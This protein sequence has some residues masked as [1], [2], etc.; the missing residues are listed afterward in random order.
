MEQTM[1]IR[2]IGTIRKEEKKGVKIQAQIEQLR[3]YY[4]NLAII[5]HTKREFILDFCLQIPSQSS[6]QLV[7]RLA[8][9]PGHVKAIHK[10]LGGV[11]EEYEKQFG[12][13]EPNLEKV[14][15]RTKSNGRK[16]VTKNSKKKAKGKVKKKRATK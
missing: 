7:A 9:S 16:L 2:K 3:A 13:I 10:V 6:T 11:I 4:M 1:A 8:T 15:P 12:E 5:T 14:A